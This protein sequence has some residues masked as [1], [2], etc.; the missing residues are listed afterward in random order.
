[1]RSISGG[2][3]LALMG[4]AGSALIVAAYSLVGGFVLLG[5]RPISTF[6]SSGPPAGAVLLGVAVLGLGLAGLVVAYGLVRRRSWARPGGIAIFS[7]AT[8][9]L[10]AMGVAGITL[11]ETVVPLLIFVAAAWNLFRPELRAELV[12]ATVSVAPASLPSGQI[13]SE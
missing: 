12:G 4:V 5:S 11:I 10:V 8:A 3:S 2:R 9:A 13:A 6:E 7:I 1:M